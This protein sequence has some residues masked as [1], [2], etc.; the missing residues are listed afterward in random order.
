RGRHPGRNRDERTLV[1]LQ[2]T[3][4]LGERDSWHI[5]RADD[6]TGV[7]GTAIAFDVRRGVELTCTNGRRGNRGLRLTRARNSRE[8]WPRAIGRGA[9][10]NRRPGDRTLE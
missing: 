10:E 8:L 2:R 4:A 7:R 3:V 6:A 1:R 9:A 5:A